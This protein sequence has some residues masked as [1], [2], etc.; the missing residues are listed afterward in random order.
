MGRVRAQTWD[1]SCDTQ[2]EQA[3]LSILLDKPEA[4]SST[5]FAMSKD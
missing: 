1:G 2:Q 4:D 3:Y 5:D